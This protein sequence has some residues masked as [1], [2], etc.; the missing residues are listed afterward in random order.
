MTRLW[1]RLV[2]W[3]VGASVAALC[4]AAAL[5]NDARRRE[6]FWSRAVSFGASY[7]EPGCDG[8]IFVEMA[9]RDGVYRLMRADLRSGAKM[10]LS[11]GEETVVSGLAA[12]D[13]LLYLCLR[14]NQLDVVYAGPGSLSRRFVTG[15]IMRSSKLAVSPGGRIATWVQDGSIMVMDLQRW[16]AAP[17]WAVPGSHQA[18]R[19]RLWEAALSGD[20]SQVALVLSEGPAFSLIVCRRQ[21]GDTVARYASHYPLFRPRWLADGSGVTA[22]ENGPREKRVLALDA[23]NGKVSTV[24]STNRF[25][26]SAEV[27]PGGSHLLLTL[28]DSDRFEGYFGG[29]HVF[30]ADLVTGSLRRIGS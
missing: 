13:R 1:P 8:A 14:G 29:L 30:E 10:Q 25:I 28:G 21:G 27:H 16:V 4:V 3:L 6:E 2:P 22:V 15:S 17:M 19:G 5:H 23:R 11:S 20:G 9:Y 26:E 18:F 12:G 24:Y 7:T